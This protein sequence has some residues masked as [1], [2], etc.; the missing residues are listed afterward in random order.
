[1]PKYGL[2]TYTTPNLGDDVQSLAARQYLPR[3]DQLVDRDELS[4]AADSEP[5]HMIM[6]GWWL[7]N[8]TDWPPPPSIKPLWV[9]FHAAKHARP[10]LTSSESIAYF[11]NHGPIGCRDEST[12]SLLSENGV[13]AFYSACLTLTLRRPDATATRQGTVFCDPFGADA[14]YKFHQKGEA[15]YDSLLDKLLGGT[16][17]P[18]QVHVTNEIDGTIPGEVRLQMAEEQLALFANARLVVTCRIHCA[19]PCLAFGTPVLFVIPRRGS[20][21]FYGGMVGA[22]RWLFTRNRLS[23]KR[24]PGLVELM[25]SVRIQDVERSRVEFDFSNPP[26]NP[27]SI[28]PLAGPLRQRCEE[29]I[30]QAEL[31]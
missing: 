24:F 5:L 7:Q 3:V 29:F 6:N 4:K 20:D 17:V 10:Q 22:L 8:A 21:L 11:Q 19:L 28:E 26:E 31:S 25:H 30:Q 23:D 16:E 27:K 9:A 14:H 12:F 2:L 15:Y 13:D 1:M 18:D